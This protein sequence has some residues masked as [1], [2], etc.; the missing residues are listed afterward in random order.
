MTISVQVV[1]MPAGPNG[2]ANV[3]A[4]TP[5]EPAR[6]GRASDVYIGAPTKCQGADGTDAA[7]TRSPTVFQIQRVGARLMQQVCERWRH[8]LIIRMEHR[9]HLRLR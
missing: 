4:E 5:R 2:T 1:N 6:T 9:V 7:L 3:M 8:F